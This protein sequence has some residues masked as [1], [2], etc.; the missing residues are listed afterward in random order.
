MKKSGNKFR[1]L[2]KRTKNRNPAIIKGYIFALSGPSGS[3]KTTLAQK[4]LQDSALKNK[5]KKS[6]SFTTRPK[7]SNEFKNKDYF[8]I[9][10]EEF[11]Q[12]LRAKKI[13]EWTKY[14]GYYYGTPKEFI[15]G[16]LKKGKNVLLCVDLKGA[17][18]LKKF[19]PNNTVTIFIKPPSFKELQKRIENRCHEISKE[20]VS[21]RVELARKEVL[22]AEKFD[23]RLENKN[24]NSATSRL[25]DIILKKIRDNKGR[26]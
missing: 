5:L 19:Y 4:I 10:A 13:L 18:R 11:K 6:T 21:L 12:G 3:G 1:I 8:F 20:E 9:T 16:Q 24:L 15:D 14:L 26:R 2:N 22:A 23:Y 17:A 7:R 25:K